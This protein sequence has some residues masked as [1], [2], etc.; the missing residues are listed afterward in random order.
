[1]STIINVVGIFPTQQ[2]QRKKHVMQS[3]KSSFQPKGHEF[4]PFPM[5]FFANNQNGR[6]NNPK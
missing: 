3:L 1:M 6:N 5:F 2:F 4:N